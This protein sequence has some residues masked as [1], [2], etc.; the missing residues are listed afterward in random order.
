MPEEM[1]A[2]KPLTFDEEAKRWML[3]YIDKFYQEIDICFKRMEFLSDWLEILELNNLIETSETEFP[4][5]AQ[6]LVESYDELSEKGTLKEIARLRKC[7]KT[8]K[9]TKEE[10]LGWTFLRFLEFVIE[11]SLSNSVANLPLALRLFLILNV[12]VSSCERSIF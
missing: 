5:F 11:Y 10:S 7:L 2:D 4:K 9:I 8:A 12:S 1:F 6:C 3:Q